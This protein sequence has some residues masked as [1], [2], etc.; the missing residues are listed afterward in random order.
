MIGAR[1][2]KRPRTTRRR[3]KNAFADAVF[4]SWAHSR[5]TPWNTACVRRTHALGATFPL[6]NWKISHVVHCRSAVGVGIIGTL[7]VTT[8]G[9]ESATVTAAII[10]S[11]IEMVHMM[12]KRR[13]GTPSIR[14]HP[15]QSS[16]KSSPPDQ[17]RTNPP[18]VPIQPLQHNH[19]ASPSGAL[20]VE[21]SARWKCTA[22]SSFQIAAHATLTSKHRS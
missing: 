2:K 1:S 8:L 3:D 21:E 17:Q 9:N 4:F 18:C 7:L 16:S 6:H 13:R 22:Q 20:L 10:L 19:S 11:D 14:I 5:C 12:R 15:W